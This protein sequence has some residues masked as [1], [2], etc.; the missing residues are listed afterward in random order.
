M[1]L[2]EG[3]RSLGHV[4]KEACGSLVFHSF[5]FIPAHGVNGF[6]PLNTPALISFLT[7]G[8]NAM[9]TKHGLK[10]IKLQAKINLFSL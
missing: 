3:F 6:P 5:S 9:G 10:L 1:V 2:K 8:P 7:T 4:L